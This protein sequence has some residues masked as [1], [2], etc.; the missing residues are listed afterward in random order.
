M[1][2]SGGRLVFAE[3]DGKEASKMA[4]TNKTTR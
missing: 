1:T 3:A 4:Q 2:M